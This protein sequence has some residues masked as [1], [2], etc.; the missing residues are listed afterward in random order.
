[1]TKSSQIW[2]G[3]V[4]HYPPVKPMIK[5]TLNLPVAL[6]WDV[7]AASLGFDQ[8]DLR[9]PV[10]ATVTNKSLDRW[11]PLK[12]GWRRRLVRG[13]ARCQQQFYRQSAL[14][15]EN[16]R[17]RYPRPLFTPSDMLVGA[18]DRTIDELQ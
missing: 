14:V 11:Q 13:L 12:H 1:M 8:F 5:G 16:G 2:S 17:G 4:R 3:F 18:D 15:H 7:G 9:L 6:R 10:V